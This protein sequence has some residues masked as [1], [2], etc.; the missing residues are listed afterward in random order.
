MKGVYLFGARPLR[1][2]LC[3]LALELGGE[4]S[5]DLVADQDGDQ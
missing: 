1:R 2:D 5:E 4:P 3:D